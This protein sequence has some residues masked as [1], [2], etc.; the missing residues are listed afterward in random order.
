[1]TKKQVKS[2]L[3]VTYSFNDLKSWVYQLRIVAASL[4]DGGQV[5]LAG[6]VKRVMLEL[7]ADLPLSVL[8]PPPEQDP[9]A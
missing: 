8:D 5:L 9:P 1:M 3:K 6:Q 2:P 7:V 4:E